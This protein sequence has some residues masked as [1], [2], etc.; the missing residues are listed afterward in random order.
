MTTYELL[1]QQQISALT[2]CLAREQA[3]THLQQQRLERV[4]YALR[5]IPSTNTL[6]RV[7]AIAQGRCPR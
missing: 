1:L 5:R 2:L 3:R 7:L 6:D 4:C